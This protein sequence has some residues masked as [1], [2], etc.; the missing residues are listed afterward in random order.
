MMMDT[1]YEDLKIKHRKID[2]KLDALNN[3]K[4]QAVSQRVRELSN[5]IN[6]LQGDTQYLQ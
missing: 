6:E 4:K 3:K 1:T 5:E 2:Q